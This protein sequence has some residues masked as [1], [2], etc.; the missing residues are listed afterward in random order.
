MTERKHLFIIGCP[1][2]GTTALANLLA[3]HPDVVMGIERYGHRAF[4]GSFSL[5]PDLFEH[6]RFISFNDGDTFYSSFDFASRAYLN[7]PEKFATAK[8][9]GDKIPTLYR[10]LDRLFDAFPGPLIVLFIFRNI[11]DVAASYKLRLLDPSDDWKKGVEDAVKDW[12]Q[13]LAAFKAHSRHPSVIPLVYEDLFT[14]PSPIE[15]LLSALG[16]DVDASFEPVINGLLSRSASLESQ[17]KRDLT[18]AEVQYICLN[19]PFGAYR[20]VVDQARERN[21]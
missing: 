1:R 19:A 4:P 5:S 21:S 3:Q 14:D 12:T 10:T 13:A 7:V 2:S 18:S 8:Y 6:D 15:A 17:R 16:L 11:F 9:V 20:T